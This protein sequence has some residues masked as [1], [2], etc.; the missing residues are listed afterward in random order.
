MRYR[1]RVILV[2]KVGSLVGLITVKDVLRFIAQREAE[3][4]S[5]GTSRRGTGL[6]GLLEE[7]WFWVLERLRPL[8]PR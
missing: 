2:E 4:A 8:L 5:L 3:E 1:P 7:A 6:D